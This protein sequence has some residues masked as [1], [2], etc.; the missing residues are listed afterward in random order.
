MLLLFSNELCV[1]GNS[2]IINYSYSILLSDKKVTETFNNWYVSSKKG[3]EQR[4]G[5]M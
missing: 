3:I 2:I 1:Y 5:S 4:Q